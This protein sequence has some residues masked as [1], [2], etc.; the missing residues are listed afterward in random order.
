MEKY[1]ENILLIDAKKET[2]YKAFLFCPLTG[3]SLL[4]TLILK[5]FGANRY[6]R[7]FATIQ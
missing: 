2:P 7:I 4:Y 5:V 1:K 6:T 3:G